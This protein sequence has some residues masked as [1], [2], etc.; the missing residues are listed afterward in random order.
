MYPPMLEST[1]TPGSGLQPAPSGSKGIGPVPLA[2][3]ILALVIV[4]GVVTGL[5]VMLLRPEQVPP[6]PPPPSSAQ[7]PSWPASADPSPST[8]PTSAPPTGEAPAGSPVSVGN[9]PTSGDL[10]WPNGQWDS[11][12]TTDAAGEEPASQCQTWRPSQL[13]GLTGSAGREYALKG[14]T[15][16]R[17]HAYVLSF[18]SETEAV[19]AHDQ[20]FD[21]AVGCAGRLGGQASERHQADAPWGSGAFVDVVVPGPERTVSTGVGRVGNRL[22]WLVVEVDGTDLGAI[23]VQADP[24]RRHTMINSLPKAMRR[25]R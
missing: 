17:A 11:G 9:L 18:T 23:D 6:P 14:P 12:E 1:P 15:K 25:I 2:I 20:L 7:V 13:A 8:P 22:V 3:G 16:G 19:A 21:D 5:L 4:L 10:S 24:N